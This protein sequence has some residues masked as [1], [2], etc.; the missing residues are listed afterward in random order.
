M[1]KEP[2]TGLRVV[3]DHVQNSTPTLVR[4]RVKLENT[5]D[6]VTVRSP[7]M[8]PELQLQ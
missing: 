2:L 5:V 4:E 7:E 3:Q 1:V 8:P 6:Q